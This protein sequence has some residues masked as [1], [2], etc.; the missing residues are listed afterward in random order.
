MTRRKQPRRKISPFTLG[1]SVLLTVKVWSPN[2][3]ALNDAA[4]FEVK[5]LAPLGLLSPS[6]I[7]PFKMKIC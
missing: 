2:L 3:T 4:F 5:S 1:A 6:L 7:G